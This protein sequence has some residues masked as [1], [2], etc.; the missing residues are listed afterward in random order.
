MSKVVLLA[1]NAK[2]VHSSLAVWCLAGGVSQYARRQHTVEIV[3]TTIHQQDEQIVQQIA[4][5]SPDVLGISTYIWN[6]GK[7]AFLLE[8]IHQRLPDICMIL[9]GPEASFHAAYWL[10]QGADY[11]LQG[12]CERSFPAL[13]DALADDAPAALDTIPGLWRNENGI[14]IHNAVEKPVQDM[15]NPYSGA[16]FAALNGRIAYIE[17][18]RGCPF[19]CS[20][21]LSGGSDLR[22]FPIQA[23]QEQLRRLSCAGAKT[24][25]LVDRTFNCNAERAYALFEYVI[26]LDTACCFHFEVAADLFDQRTLSLLHT[27]PPGRIQLEAGLQSFYAPALK[28]VARQT[29]AKAAEQAI[30][31]LLRGQNIHMH[32]DLIAGLPF[33][34]LQHFQESFSRAYALGVHTLQLGFLKL[35]H[36]SA[37]RQQ[38][39]QW[40]IMYSQQPPY[41]IMQSPWLRAQDI[42]ILKQVENALQRA[43][44]SGRFLSTMQYVLSAAG[45]DP[46]S[47]YRGLGEA[48]PNHGDALDVYANGMYAYCARLPGV[49]A[50]ALRDAMV[51]DWLSAVKGKN[52]PSFLR[53]SSGRHK[54]L[55]ATAQAMLGRKMQRCE[56][57][58]L[59][60]GKRKGVFVDSRQKDPVTGLHM[61]HFID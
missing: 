20:F 49:D 9:G 58:V 26:N 7:L 36:G 45:M 12:E 17:T 40:G 38:A 46:F 42:N 41:E 8:R 4:A 57:A 34:E 5:L 25:K 29:N 11:V 32:V 24:I 56:A 51:C 16:Y 60:S 50:A 53:E 54:Q 21:C 61:L 31:S 52:L 18:S 48:V 23:A 2:Y 30:R 59:I 6:A 1:I 13:L 19:R 10:A 44:N 22:F 47:L 55:L 28:A 3:E 39:D 27:A 35:L 43:Y 33:E 15:I 14:T 37:L